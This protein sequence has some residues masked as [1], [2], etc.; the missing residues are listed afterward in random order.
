MVE[1]IVH[2]IMAK[3]QKE[4]GRGWAPISPSRVPPVT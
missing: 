3:K 1:N 2:L 4:R